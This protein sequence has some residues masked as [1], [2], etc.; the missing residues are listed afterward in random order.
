[1]GIDWSQNSAVYQ[2]MDGASPEGVTVPA[3]KIVVGRHNGDGAPASYVDGATLKS[4]FD[5]AL[6][7]GRWS[8][9]FMSWHFYDEVYPPSGRTA[10][11]DDVIQANWP[12]LGAT[13]TPTE[14]GETPSPIT[15]SPT[16]PTD[17]ENLK[18]VNYY[19]SSEWYFAASLRDVAAGFDVTKFEIELANGNWF[20]CSTLVDWDGTLL[21]IC[22]VDTFIALPFSVRLTA[23]NS[24]GDG[25]TLT[26]ATGID[27]FEQGNVHD[28]GYNFVSNN[29]DRRRMGDASNKKSVRNVRKPRLLSL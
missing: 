22:A 14:A 6:L 21:Y 1:M 9:G 17:S 29:N 26:S 24:D 19:S 23:F 10:L 3:S 13:P 11:I 4:I 28:F 7:I 25:D 15:P 2:I 8:T 18:I 5:D 20:E 12:E 16:M 27:S